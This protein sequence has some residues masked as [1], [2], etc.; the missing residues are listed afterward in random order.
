MTSSPQHILPSISVF[1]ARLASPPFNKK[2]L[3]ILPKPYESQPENIW[4]IYHQQKQKEDHL[5]LR[6]ASDPTSTDKKRPS[7]EEVLAEK[8]RR[9]AGASARFRDRRKQRERELQERCQVLEKRAVDLEDALRMMDP[10][11]PLIQSVDSNFLTVSQTNSVENRVILGR[12]NQ[13][14]QFIARFRVEKQSD[15]K[16][17]EELEKEV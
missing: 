8:R 3:P 5:I 7:S 13:L 9:N 17:L 4:Q 12:I 2:T 10:G 11:H 14:E 6:R 1:T 16:R 15:I